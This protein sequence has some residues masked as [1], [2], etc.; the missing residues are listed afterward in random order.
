MRWR[1]TILVGA[2]AMAMLAEVSIAQ[3]PRGAKSPGAGRETRG[4][5]QG[6]GPAAGFVLIPAGE[7]E[8]GDHHGFVD[9]KHGGD[10]TPIHRVRLDAFSMADARRHDGAVLR[11]PQFGAGTAVDRGANRRC[12]SGRRKRTAGGNAGDV[13]L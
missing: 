2:L 13:S 6:Q 1:D 12:L 9:P 5:R 10:E 11:V 4:E 8:M 3:P 7:F